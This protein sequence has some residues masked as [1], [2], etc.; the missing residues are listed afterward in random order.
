MFGNQCS[1]LVWL[2]F[3][4]AV[5]WSALTLCYNTYLVLLKLLPK[6]RQRVVEMVKK[7]A[8]PLDQPIDR[9]RKMSGEERL[10]CCLN[11]WIG[12]FVVWEPLCA[13]FSAGTAYYTYGWD[14]RLQIMLSVNSLVFTVVFCFCLGLMLGLGAHGIKDVKEYLYPVVTP[15]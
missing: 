9:W 3:G 2:V 7:S 10:D 6:W 11:Q 5:G 15:R 13:F 14:Y 12:L 1:A 4:G 8:A